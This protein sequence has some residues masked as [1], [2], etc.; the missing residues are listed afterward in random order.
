MKKNIKIHPPITNEEAYAI[1]RQLLGKVTKADLKL[2]NK[3]K[4]IKLKRRKKNGRDN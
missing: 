1:G 2:L 4:K 3:P